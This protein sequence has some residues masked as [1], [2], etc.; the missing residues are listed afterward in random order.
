MTAM[1]R[2]EKMRVAAINDLSGFGKCSLIADIS[3]LSSMGI[4]VCPVP[5][6][7]LTSQ[8]GF[9]SYHIH[10]TTDMVE[11]SIRDWKDRNETFDGILTGFMPG[12][13]V[14]D[15]VQSFAKAFRT[16][17]TIFLVDPVMGDNGD[18]YSNY[19]D[20]MLIKMKELVAMA[21]IITPNLTELCLLADEDPQSVIKEFKE[22]RDTQL[23][24]KL[25][26]KIK[27][28][29]S[30]S[31]VVTGVPLDENII[32]NIIVFQHGS[33]VIKSSHNG[34]SYSG[35][36]D[37][38]AASLMGNILKGKDILEAVRTTAE[39]INRSVEA[40]SSTDRNYGVDYEQI[41]AEGPGGKR[42]L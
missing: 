28:S 42:F 27:S 20:E 29:D 10:D 5:T 33:H 17:K 21:D 30:Q 13:K 1:E 40:T 38:F 18:R 6:A 39:F 14:I 36:G 35:T 26:S 11:Y 25:A 23:I 31:I 34:L 15:D 32:S 12:E 24:I 41:L 16:E 19:S 8:T 2:T 7:V 37:L 9:P 22:K 3:V 4:E